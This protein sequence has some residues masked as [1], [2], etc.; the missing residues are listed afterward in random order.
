MTRWDRASERSRTFTALLFVGAIVTL[1]SPLGTQAQQGV[2]TGPDELVAIQVDLGT[3]VGMM[4]P[5]WRYFGYD[6][7]NATYLPQG[8]QLLEDFAALSPVPVYA[9][10]HHLLTSDEGSRFDL[11]W[12]STNAYTEDADGNPVYDWAVMDSIFD[13]WIESGVKPL[14]EIGF[15]P[16]ALSSNPEPYRHSWTQEDTDIEGGWNDPPTDYEKWAELVYQWVRHSIERYGEDEVETWWWQTWNE[17]DIRWWTGSTEEYIKLHDYTA[18]AVK[19]ALPTARVGGPETARAANPE[20]AAFIRQFLDHCRDGVN[21][22][23]GGEGCELDVFTFH[24]KGRPEVMDGGYVRMDMGLQLSQVAAGFE[25]LASYPE[26][27]DVPIIIGESDPE[28]CAACS[29]DYHPHNVY[30]N[31]TMFSS[32][33]ASSFAKKYELADEIGVDFEG[34]L[35]WTFTFPNQPPFRGFRAFTTTDGIHKP[36]LNVMKMF[37]MMQGDRVE[38]STPGNPYT[39][40]AVIERGVRDDPDINGLASRD[41]DAAAVMV[42]YYHDDDLPMPSAQVRVTVDDIP[43]DRVLL[44]HYRIDHAHSNSFTAWQEMG[45][46]QNPTPE[47]IEILREAGELELLESPVWLRTTNDTASVEFVLPWQGVSLLTLSW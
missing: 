3:T 7:P 33:T 8:R 5:V 9:R 1:S 4:T 2:G 47:Q 42:W 11:K 30:R 6:E 28:G 12:G 39:A 34:A 32:Y 20:S 23:T 43:A 16:K 15:M 13:A 25:L 36:V 10:A 41:G 19:R 46:P 40:R 26:F 14:V 21:Y 29:A 22:A 45:S 18:D 24:A 44:H 31:G 17:P 27:R 37:G 38:V 35:S